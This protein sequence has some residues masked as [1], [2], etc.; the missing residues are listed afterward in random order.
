MHQR[1][2][3][4]CNTLLCLT[5]KS[6]DIFCN[7]SAHYEKLAHCEKMGTLQKYMT[8]YKKTGTWNWHTGT[9]NHKQEPLLLLSSS[10]SKTSQNIKGQ[11]K[12]K[13]T[14]KHCRIHLTSPPVTLNI[15]AVLFK[16]DTLIITPICFLNGELSPAQT[17]RL[18]FVHI[19]LKRLW[20]QLDNWLQL[21][22]SIFSRTAQF[23]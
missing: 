6:I 12:T 15:E 11:K 5:P 23:K 3:K 17:W 1:T 9:R 2:T 22:W 20:T 7:A 13:K 21:K 19:F 8:H 16:V 14:V 4:K 18:S 10:L